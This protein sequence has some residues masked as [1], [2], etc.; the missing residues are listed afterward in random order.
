MLFNNEFIAESA[1]ERSRTIF[2][3]VT[4]K[5][6]V[7][8]FFMRHSVKSWITHNL[9]LVHRVTLGLCIRQREKHVDN[10]VLTD[11]NLC[12]KLHTSLKWMTNNAVT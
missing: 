9:R 12:W 6:T 3:E 2:G 1:Y 4:G 10:I 5:N 11:N 7:S 8:S